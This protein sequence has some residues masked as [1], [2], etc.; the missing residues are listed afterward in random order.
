MANSKR[1][2]QRCDQTRIVT[3]AEQSVSDMA[4][5]IDEIEPRSSS[6]MHVQSDCS[7]K[8]GHDAGPN[9]DVAAQ[10]EAYRVGTVTQHVPRGRAKQPLQSETAP[11]TR[12]QC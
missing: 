11:D 6:Q 12:W 9:A 7:V 4:V 1:E 8:N 3:E 10:V 5:L 2:K